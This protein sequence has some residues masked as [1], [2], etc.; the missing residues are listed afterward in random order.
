[1]SQSKM[2]QLAKRFPGLAGRPGIE[3][4]E[5]AKICRWLGKVSSGEAHAARFLLCLWNRGFVAEPSTRFDLVDAWSTWDEK[6]RAALR[7]WLDKPFVP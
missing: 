2:S 5:A 7:T 1:M 4:F 6:N 3:P